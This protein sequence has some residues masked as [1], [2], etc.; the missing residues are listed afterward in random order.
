MRLFDE[1]GQSRENIKTQVID[2]FLLEYEAKMHAEPDLYDANDLVM[3]DK[4]RQGEK[5]KWDVQ[6]ADLLAKISQDFRLSP[7]EGLSLREC[8][9]EN[10][11]LP[12][13]YTEGLS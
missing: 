10:A 5:I 4:L 2:R 6:G 7:E 11:I 8:V 1:R 3:L 9:F 12:G 13:W